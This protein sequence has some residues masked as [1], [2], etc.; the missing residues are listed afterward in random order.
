MRIPR[1]L[2]EYQYD[3][4]KLF[5]PNKYTSTAVEYCLLYVPHSGYFPK[6]IVFEKGFTV[7]SLRVGVPYLK[8][9]V[10]TKPSKTAP[11][12]LTISHYEIPQGFGLGIEDE[13]MLN[14][15][16]PREV[17]EAI[18]KD[19]NAPAVLKAVLEAMPKTKDEWADVD[20]DIDF[21]YSYY[22]ELIEEI[23]NYL[24]SLSIKVEESE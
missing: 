14:A 9:C 1:Y 2:K 4:T 22:T 23:K 3:K 19:P 16:I 5:V 21:G 18:L 20:H 12:F 15:V 7:Y 10:M 17:Y 24:E 6:P 11:I 13:P 8:F